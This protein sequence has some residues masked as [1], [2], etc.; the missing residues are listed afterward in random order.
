MN[1]KIERKTRV[2]E[3]RQTR[4]EMMIGIVI[5]DVIIMIAGIWFFPNKII[6]LTGVILGAVIAELLLHHMFQSLDVALDLEPKAAEKYARSKSIKRLLM[7][8]L[9]VSIAGI[10]PQY[11]NVVGTCFGVLG[12]K[13]SAYLQPLVHKYIFKQ[14]IK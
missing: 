2:E 13:F 10:L 11:F 4:K 7:M 9:A 14:E 6:Y 3:A 5:A 8:G 1:Q 12:L